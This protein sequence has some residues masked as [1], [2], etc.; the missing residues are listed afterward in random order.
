[1]RKL[2]ISANIEKWNKEINHSKQEIIDEKLPKKQKHDLKRKVHTSTCKI[3]PDRIKD[4]KKQR[5][6]L[7]V[8]ST[9]NEKMNLGSWKPDEIERFEWALNQHGKDYKMIA[10]HVKTRSYQAVVTRFNHNVEDKSAYGL[11]KK[12]WTA[13]EKQKFTDA[14]REVGQNRMKISQLVGSKS[15]K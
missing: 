13:D 6:K 7:E 10:E 8:K 3:I 2:A 1:M 5:S 4:L 15:V 9:E 12:F 11:H 14:V